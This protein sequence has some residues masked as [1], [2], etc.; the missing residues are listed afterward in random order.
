MLKWENLFCNEIFAS[1]EDIKAF[2][3]TKEN[4]QNIYKMMNV[5]PR[6]VL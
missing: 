6:S 1:A 5:S 2:M 3:K 4:Q